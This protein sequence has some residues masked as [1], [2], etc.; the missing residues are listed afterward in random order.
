[1]MR[2]L[3]IALLMMFSAAPA[4]AEWKLIDFNDG[5]AVYINDFFRPGGETTRM[6]MLIEYR[7][8]TAQGSLSVK[9]LWEVDCPARAMRTLRYASYPLRMGFGDVIKVDETPSEWIKPA[10]DS[11]QETM[12]VLICRFDPNE[13]PKT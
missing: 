7:E 13:G 1:M 2:K 12:F 11:P 4:L 6:W 10:E 5:E 9:L 3:L 8:R